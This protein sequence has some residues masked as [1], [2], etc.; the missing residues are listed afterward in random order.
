MYV[1]LVNNDNTMSAP[2]KQRIMQRSKLVDDLW[3]LVPELYN[4][5]NMNDCIVCLEYLLPVSK[6][7][8]TEILSLC[9][10]KYE[11]H[12]KYVLPL[13]TELTS[14]AGDIELQLTFLKS[15]M[16]DRG[17]ITQRV[18]KV[19]GLS[20][21]V[22]PIK[23]WSDVIPDNALSSIDQRL[24]KMDA[25][26]RYMEDMNRVVLDEKAD[27]IVYDEENNSLQL[28]SNGRLIGDIVSLKCENM[29]DGLPVVDFNKELNDSDDTPITDGEVENVVEF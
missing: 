5:I 6:Q 8:K 10:D 28:T 17:V 22:I 27:N 2:L 12:L 9:S 4:N 15:D 25:Q 7:Y 23:K 20:I 21:T 29:E 24:I 16:N 18:R 1:I 11:D 14:E 19:E 26:L 3:F 13:D